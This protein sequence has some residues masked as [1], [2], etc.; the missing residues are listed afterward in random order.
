VVFCL[1]KIKRRLPSL[2][3]LVNR[4]D[5]LHCTNNNHP[6]QIKS[7]VDYLA[8]PYVYGYVSIPPAT[9]VF[10]TAQKNQSPHG[11]GIVKIGDW[12]DGRTNVH[13]Y[14]KPRIYLFDKIPT[15]KSLP[16]KWGPQKCFC[17]LHQLMAILYYYLWRRFYGIHLFASKKV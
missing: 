12:L 14:L 7:A 9:S 5:L 6:T 8:A 16:G 15:S 13:G 17:K 10:P 1:D 11:T 3:N 4:Q 2:Y